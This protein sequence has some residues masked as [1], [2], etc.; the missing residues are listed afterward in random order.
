LMAGTGLV[1]AGNK[2]HYKNTVTKTT[3]SFP[4]Q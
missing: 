3:W 2:L 4:T 1:S